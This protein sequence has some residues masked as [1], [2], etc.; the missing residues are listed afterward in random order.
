MKRLS[1][2]FLWACL[3]CLCFAGSGYATNIVINPGTTLAGNAAALGAFQRAADSWS[4]R[5]AD[6]VTVTIN[7]DLAALGTGVLGSANTVTLSWGYNNVRNLMVT[8]AADEASNG[9]VSYL[10]TASQI[11]VNLPS[12]FSL[13]SDISMTKANLKAMGYEGLDGMFGAKDADITFSTNFNFDYDNSDG[14]SAGSYDFETVATHE[15]GHVLGFIS[16]VDVV[17]YYL[18]I[19]ETAEISL[20]ALDLFR[21]GAATPTDEASF[22]TGVRSLLTGGES[23]FCDVDN[24]W[25]LSTGRYTGDGQ[26][27]SHWKADEKTGVYIGMMDPSLA[28]ATVQEI[29]GADLRAF[30]LIG[31]DVTPVPLPPAMILFGSGL[32]AVFA[33]ARRRRKV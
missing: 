31:W 12:G 18:S 27:A 9:I 4:Q 21:F 7:A 29:T 6:P 25:S 30:D 23:Y 26:Q 17:D 14:V 22:T 33:G 24:K 32:V 10:P 11:G 2:S 5:L 19:G 15:I 3:I 20:Y 8:D 16:A 13:S 1:R 28:S